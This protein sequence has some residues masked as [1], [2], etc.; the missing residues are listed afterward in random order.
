VVGEIGPL[1]TARGFAVP[2]RPGLHMRTLA[3][4]IACVAAEGMKL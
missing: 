1:P 3:D 2:G 4:V